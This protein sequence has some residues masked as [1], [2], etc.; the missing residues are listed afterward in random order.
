MTLARLVYRH[1]S[2]YRYYHADMRIRARSPA[3]HTPDSFSRSFLYAHTC[4]MTLAGDA[5]RAVLYMSISL[6]GGGPAWP[7]GAIMPCPCPARML[8]PG[9]T[10]VA[11]ERR[12]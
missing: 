11:D 4:V 3:R 7:C 12:Y 1:P 9:T 8:P 2:A 6:G 10:E 5:G